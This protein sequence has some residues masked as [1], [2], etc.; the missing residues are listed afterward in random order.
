MEQHSLTHFPSQ[1]WCKMCVESRGHDSPHREHWKIDEVVPQIQFDYG[2]IQTPLGGTAR[3][4]RDLG[5][6]GFLSYGH[7]ERVL[8]L[9]LDKVAK[10][11][12]P[13]GKDRQISTTSVTTQSTRA[14]APRR[15]SSPQCAVLLE[16]IW[17]SFKKIP[18]FDATTHSPMLPWT[19]RDAAWAHTIHREKRHTHDAVR[20][21]RGQK[22]KKEILPRSKQVLARRPGA[23]VNQLLQK[24]V[25]GLRLER[26]T[27]S[28]E[29]LVGTAAGVMRSRAVRRLQEPARW[30]PEALKAMLFTPWS[31][32]LILPGRPRLQRPTY[33]EP[34][35]LERCQDSS[36]LQ[37]PQ[38]HRNRSQRSSRHCRVMQSSQQNVSFRR[39]FRENLSQL[40]LPP[41]LAQTHPRKF[42]I[43]RFQNLHVK[44]H[45]RSENSAFNNVRR[46]RM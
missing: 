1:L 23:S 3:W 5:Y 27:L 26:N 30:V 7:I 38:E 39:R 37:Q 36:R 25:T 2:Y 33:E 13:E 42:L 28:D 22:Y 21:I 16:H 8:Q 10:E 34:M 31:P 6:E 46:Q 17:Q 20:K 43:H 32:H 15:M 24:R 9:L 45:P 44:C 4:V 19:I 41:V 35:W 18:S 11:C 29:H 12:R 40:H 14:T